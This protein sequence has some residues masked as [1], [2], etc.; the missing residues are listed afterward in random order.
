MYQFTELKEYVEREF[1]IETENIKSS[2][3][4]IVEKFTRKELDENVLINNEGIYYKDK[5]GKLHKGFLYIEKYNQEVA[6]MR[7][8]NTMPRFH[9]LNCRTLNKQRQNKNF[10]GH[11]V[12]SNEPQF[13]KD[14]DDIVKDLQ[15][16]GYCKNDHDEI[17]EVI[18]STVYTDIFIKDTE[19]DG[20]FSS[21]DMPLDINLD[22]FGYTED[23]DSASKDYRSKMKYT[24]EDCGIK[25]NK[26]YSDSYYLETHHINGNKADNSQSNLKCL[27]ILC[28]SNSNDYHK[29]N[30]KNGKNRKK[31]ED[32]IS[33]FRDELVNIGNKHLVV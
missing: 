5:N 27:C 4:S 20:N 3:V 21:E 24:C 7:G 6:S 22:E 1:G 28:H 19:S 30:Y 10:D 14:V 29:Q 11:Y 2:F 33:L 8:W 31:L 25:L 15:L 32:F 16:C 18:S 12:F 13:K 9:I 26:N 23:W 17:T